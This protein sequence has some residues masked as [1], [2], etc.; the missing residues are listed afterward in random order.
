VSIWEIH[1]TC[2]LQGL[3]FFLHAREY[4]CP[5]FHGGILLCCIYI[6]FLC[7]FVY[8]LFVEVFVFFNSWRLAYR[9]YGEIKIVN[10]IYQKKVH[11]LFLFLERVQEPHVISYY[12]DKYYVFFFYGTQNYF[13]LFNTIKQ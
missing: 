5:L 9:L 12:V 13:Y 3:K 11:R 8:F 2:F 1:L 7:L 10:V 4:K 6:Y